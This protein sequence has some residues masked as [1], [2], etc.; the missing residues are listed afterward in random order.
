MD[1]VFDSTSSIFDNLNLHVKP[2]DSSIKNGMDTRRAH[3][4]NGE[5][6]QK[7]TNSIQQNSSSVQGQQQNFQ[8][9]GETSKT[10]NIEGEWSLDHFEIMNEKAENCQVLQIFGDAKSLE[11]ALGLG[12][13]KKLVELAEELPKTSNFKF[14]ISVDSSTSSESKE[15]LSKDQKT[16]TN[17]PIER[18]LESI[19][20]DMNNAIKDRDEKIGELIKE[21]DGFI[22]KKKK[23]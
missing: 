23:W 4:G 17:E 11:S 16:V 18:D 6:E 1:N 15:F 3:R 2:M 21:I 10:N 20:I 13:A 14:Q 19:R 5:K 22:L 8:R 9:S 12:L 7:G